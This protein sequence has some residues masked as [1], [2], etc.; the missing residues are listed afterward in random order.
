MYA[1]VRQ[2]EGVVKVY[3]AL[4][5]DVARQFKTGFFGITS[6]KSDAQEQDVVIVPL[7]GREE[8]IN[9]NEFG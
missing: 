7:R 9:I 8:R 6:L 5:R 1:W 4:V 2:N 3:Y